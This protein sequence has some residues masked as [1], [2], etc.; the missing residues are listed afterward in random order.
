MHCTNFDKKKSTHIHGT[1]V[2]V[3][4]RVHSIINKHA[5]KQGS[6]TS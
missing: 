4:K 6:A 1:L 5:A 3:E 2:K